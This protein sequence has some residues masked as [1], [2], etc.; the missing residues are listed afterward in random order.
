MSADKVRAE[1]ALPLIHTPHSWRCQTCLL[2]TCNAGVSHSQNMGFGLLQP[3]QEFGGCDSKGFIIK[4][5]IKT[6]GRT[7]GEPWPTRSGKRKNSLAKI[8]KFRQ[9]RPRHL[10]F[11]CLPYVP[12]LNLLSCPFPRPKIATAFSNGIHHACPPA[13]V[14]THPLQHHHSHRSATPTTPRTT[15]HITKAL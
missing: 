8:A 2:C 1:P 11:P 3:W 9:G 15:H 12:W 5:A 10:S 13:P 7:C 14:H 6:G 4:I